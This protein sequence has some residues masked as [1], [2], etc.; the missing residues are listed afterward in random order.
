MHS[1]KK[2]L[3][4]IDHT[5]LSTL[6]Y[7]W[8]LYNLVFGLIYWLMTDFSEHHILV[9]DHQ[10]IA[11]DFY[12]LM[13][14]LYFSL[15]TSTTLGYG[16]IVPMG[17]L[18]LVAALQSAIGL[19]I[20]TF[21]ISRLVSKKQ[22]IM[23]RQ[24]HST[25][26]DHESRTLRSGMYVFRE[27][28]EHLIQEIRKNTLKQKDIA[29]DL[30]LRLIS[31]YTHISEILSNQQKR[32]HLNELEDEKFL[33]HI[34]ISLNVLIK[35]FKTLSQKNT[36]LKAHELAFSM[37]LIDNRIVETCNVIKER[38]HLPHKNK[39]ITKILN[40]LQQIKMLTNEVFIP[41]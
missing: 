28:M 4:F 20:L 7:L 22:E 38:S 15:V 27:K 21:I 18:R 30:N 6:V 34:A 36:Q 29:E 23:I 8:L 41:E 12:G 39:M 35:C 19:L 11:R 5:R 14:S 24:I 26:I 13:D 16:D 40:R 10:P 17:V 9:F 32:E 3:K 31:F 33:L 25:S 2:L 1:E 37:D